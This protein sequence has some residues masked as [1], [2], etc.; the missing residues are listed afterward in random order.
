MK[1]TVYKYSVF[2]SKKGAG[3]LAGVVICH[4]QVPLSDSQK[5]MITTQ[6]GA[7]ECVFV[8][9]INRATYTFSFFSPKSEMTLCGHATIA[10]IVALHNLRMIIDN[11]INI[12]TKAGL[13][14]VHTENIGTQVKVIMRQQNPKFEFF[15]GNIL[16]LADAL[17]INVSDIAVDWPIVYASTG[18][19]T[20]LLPIKKLS[21][22][23][24][25]KPTNSY[26]PGI[27]TAFPFASI[28]PFCI[29]Q[30][31]AGEWYARHFSGATTGT[32]ED[33]VTGTAAGALAAYLRWQ[34]GIDEKYFIMTQG[35]ELNQPG[36]VEVKLENNKKISIIGTA[37]ENGSIGI[38][39]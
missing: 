26:F 15:T 6:I 16:A 14:E 38:D 22:F 36:R 30:T 1:I 8:E 39:I 34:K 9:K 10:G 18:A 24:I 11:T 7:T 32:I 27:L 31:I 21:T 29:E 37:V 17:N 19:W 33:P 25:M 3:N 5:K 13:L 20:L 12:D 4:K 35:H 2:T 23:K 28:H